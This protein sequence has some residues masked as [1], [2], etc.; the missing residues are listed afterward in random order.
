MSNTNLIKEYI[1]LLIESRLSSRRRRGQANIKDLS[2]G[3][4]ERKKSGEYFIVL[5]DEKNP[6]IISDNNRFIKIKKNAPSEIYESSIDIEEVAGPSRLNRTDVDPYL[7]SRMLKGS[8]NP[9]VV[10]SAIN[11]V[12]KPHDDK[13]KDNGYSDL[14][15]FIL[16]DS[17][18]KYGLV[19]A[20]I[21]SYYTK[22]FEICYSQEDRLSAYKRAG[23]TG[24]RNVIGTVSDKFHEFEMNSKLSESIDKLIEKIIEDGSDKIKGVLYTYTTDDDELTLEQY[25]SNPTET[26]LKE[27]GMTLNDIYSI[28]KRCLSEYYNDT[29]SN[30]KQYVNPD[31]ETITLSEIEYISRSAL[32]LAALPF[33]RKDKNKDRRD[34]TNLHKYALQQRDLSQSGMAHARSE[35]RRGKEFK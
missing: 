30:N 7:V 31:Y 16:L 11:K 5:Y 1:S 19:N 15:T 23:F 18:N 13:L 20:K 27:M 34:K 21:S 9:R 28:L 2:I 6:N 4:I 35:Y 17:V 8:F 14:G 22:F 25:F 24:V 10:Q 3:A 12:K 32:Y 26:N 29:D 33:R